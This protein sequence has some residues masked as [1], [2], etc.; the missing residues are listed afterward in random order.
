LI[1]RLQRA[2][3]EPAIWVLL[4]QALGDSSAA[5]SQRKPMT[6]TFAFVVFGLALLFWA[7][8][9]TDKSPGH[10]ATGAGVGIFALLI[11]LLLGA[12]H[13]HDHDW[14]DRS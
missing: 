8:T 14:E 9:T 6:I 5:S 12:S 10:R 2:A 4:P 3:D 1:H 11:A 13:S 7:I